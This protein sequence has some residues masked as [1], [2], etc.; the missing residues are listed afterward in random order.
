MIDPNRK[1]SKTVT[2]APAPAAQAR[3]Q[4]A[5]DKVA[6]PRSSGDRI[7]AV[8]PVPHSPAVGNQG[9]PIYKMGVTGTEENV[10]LVMADGEIKMV[11]V[12]RPSAG[13]I[14]VVDQVTFTFCTSTLAKLGY[15]EIASQDSQVSQISE[16]L[17][18]L[19]GFGITSERQTGTNFY[20]RCFEIGKFGQ[21]GLGG[22]ADT[23]LVH[24][25]GLGALKALSGWEQRLFDFLKTKANRPKIT[26]LDL[27]HDDFF[28]ETISVDWALEQWQNGGFTWRGAAPNVEQIGNWLKPNGNGRTFAVG[29][30]ASGKYLRVYEKG[31]KEG[32]KDSPWTRFEVELKSKD[33]VIPFDA[34]LDPSSYLA[35]SY[36]CTDFLNLQADRIKTE[37]K[38]GEYNYQKM[39]EVTRVQMG[40]QLR[41]LKNFLQDAD[42]VLNLVMHPDVNAIPK[43]LAMISSGINTMPS[44]IHHQPLDRINPDLIDFSV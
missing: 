29:A 18:K 13:Q 43:R 35:G 28:A 21:V 30:R 7:I 11:A 16:L 1:D 25:Y 4:G 33:R 27:A 37:K 22:Q 44:F 32:C 8:K 17:E 20:K 39:V 3:T 9:V 12:R 31:R 2:G 19:F 34:L 14:A 15:E 6:R 10:Q 23:V 26:R 42:E 40:R 24:I 5:T 41:F 36:P 38:T